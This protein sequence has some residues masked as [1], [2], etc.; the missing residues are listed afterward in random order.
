MAQESRG[1][2]EKRDR[3]AGGFSDFLS[4]IPK[5]RLPGLRE[6]EKAAGLLERLLVEKNI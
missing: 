1:N 4:G 6:R 2:M 5:S 3:I